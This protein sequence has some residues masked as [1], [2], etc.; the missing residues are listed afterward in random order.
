MNRTLKAVHVFLCLLPL[1]GVATSAAADTIYACIN[2]NSGAVRI[3]S[4]TVK[5]IKNEVASSWNTTGP[6]GDPGEPGTL[7][8]TGQQGLQGQQG[9]SGEGPA[10]SI[11]RL[12]GPNT[13]NNLTSNSDPG[14]ELIKLDL[15]AGAY[16]ITA[17]V[18]VQSPTNGGEPYYAH[19]GLTPSDT[20]IAGDGDEGFGAGTRSMI[21][22]SMLHTF[23]AAGSV[24]LNCN[25]S[26]LSPG[27]WI[28]GNLTA[29]QV[30]STTTTI[31][32]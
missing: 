25:D 26:E 6:K 28:K 3:V 2:T 15:P 4:P 10:Y 1:V 16:A 32:W 18:W 23:A 12:F 31:L 30:Q 24:I 22:L 27:M 7:G 17:A 20:A 13:E 8:Q 9:P 5:C 19:C 11:R 29:I 14:D 21:P